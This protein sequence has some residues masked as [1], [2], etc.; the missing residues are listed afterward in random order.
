MTTITPNTYSLAEEQYAALIQRLQS[1]ETQ[2]M[3]YGELE[4]LIRVEGNE[5]LRRLLQSHL[6][7]MG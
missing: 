3:E 6:D 2:T 5:L 1:S 4:E 7:A